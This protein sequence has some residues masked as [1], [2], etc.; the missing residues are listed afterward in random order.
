MFIRSLFFIAAITFSFANSIHAQIAEKAEDVAPLLV[1]ET[2]PNIEVIGT[3]EQT[4][5]FLEVLGKKPTVLIFYRGGWCPYCSAHLQDL[6]EIELDI[7]ELGYQVIAVS[8]DR[9]DKLKDIEL[10]DDINYRLYSD[11]S[12]ELM[13]ATG[14]AFKAPERYGE[15]L[16]DWSGG[17]ND[18]FLPVPSVFIVNQEGLIEF[19]YINPNYK[20]RMSGALL[21]AVLRV[22]KAESDE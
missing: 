17:K 12:G 10:M 8:P 2:F 21:L 19:E 9:I 11:A 16:L 6:G 5:G 3:D 13:Q 15:R 1:G 20:Q 4:I 14:I 7:I 22:L 18:G